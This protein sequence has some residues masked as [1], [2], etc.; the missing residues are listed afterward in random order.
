MVLSRSPRLERRILLCHA[1]V[2]ARDA[3]GASLVYSRSAAV[4]PSE[5]EPPSTAGSR[6]MACQAP[7][8]M[9]LHRAR[10]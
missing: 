10:V 4:A 3:D 2:V 6:R 8:G 5:T 9:A 7:V 1:V